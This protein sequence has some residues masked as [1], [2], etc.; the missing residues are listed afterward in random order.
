[1]PGL[2]FNTADAETLASSIVRSMGDIGMDDAT[3]GMTM[4]WDGVN[5]KWIL[6]SRREIGMYRLSASQVGGIAVNT[7]VLYDQTEP[8]STLTIVNGTLTIPANKRVLITAM[9]SA[10]FSNATG[11]SYVQLYDVTNLAW[12]GTEI[13][14]VAKSD[15]TYHPSVPIGKALIVTGAVPVN[16]EVRIK[17]LTGVMNQVDDEESCLILEDYT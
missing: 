11:E 16:I 12:I 8:G 6:L 7:K 13:Y 2:P 1:M 4:R 10:A 15:I 14:L 5:S 3:D 17:T 9:V